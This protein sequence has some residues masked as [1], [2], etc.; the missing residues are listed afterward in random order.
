MTGTGCGHRSLTLVGVVVESTRPIRAAHRGGGLLPAALTCLLALGALCALFVWTPPGQLLDEQVLHRAD[1]GSA[2]YENA[3]ALLAV[4]GDPLVLAGLLAAVLVVGAFGGRL[5]AAVAGSVAVG[6]SIA[7]SRLL[8]VVVPRPDLELVGSTTHNSFPSGHVAA[9]AG[10]LF[11]LL[12]ALPP[13][14]RWWCAVP[15]A[16]VVAAVGAATVIA[17]W[18]RFSDVAGAALLAAACGCVAASAERRWR[19]V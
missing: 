19:Q 3:R 18:H 9:A 4:A 11:A 2:A 15:G 10:L 12:I 5:R 6:A 1:P 8:K 17:G 14:A 13:R 7:A 16:A